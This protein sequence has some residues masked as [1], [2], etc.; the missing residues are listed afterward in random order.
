MSLALIYASIHR[1]SRH[2]EAW[3]ERCLFLLRNIGHQGFGNQDHGGDTGSILEAGPDDLG[4][5]DDTLLDHIAEIIGLG[6]ITPALGASLNGID[7]YRAVASGI[8]GNE[9]D[10]FFDSFPDNIDSGLFVTLE[11]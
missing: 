11:L 5:I 2:R 8:L 4:G 6:I 10:G 9:S 1:H 7:D 3:P